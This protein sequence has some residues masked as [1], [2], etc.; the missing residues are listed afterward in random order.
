MFLKGYQYAVSIETCNA[1]K[2]IMAC[3]PMFGNFVSPLLWHQ[4]NKNGSI[5]PSK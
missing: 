1:K 2:N 5:D 4:L 3:S